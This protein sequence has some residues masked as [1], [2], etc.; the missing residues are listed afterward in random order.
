MTPPVD[1][2]DKAAQLARRPDQPHPIGQ[3]INNMS[4]TTLLSIHASTERRTLPRSGVG[5][6]V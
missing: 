4:S 5:G 1:L 2:D 3:R 6:V